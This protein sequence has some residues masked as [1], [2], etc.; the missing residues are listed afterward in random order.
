[1]ITYTVLYL[2]FNENTRDKYE[3]YVHAK[4]GTYLHALQYLITAG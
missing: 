2:Y 3:L 4:A 1:M